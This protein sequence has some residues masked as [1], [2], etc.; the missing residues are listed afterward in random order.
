MPQYLRMTIPDLEKL[1]GLD[2]SDASPVLYLFRNGE[3]VRKRIS[4]QHPG[5]TPEE[6]EE[7]IRKFAEEMEDGSRILFGG[8]HQG[9]LTGVAGLEIGR[10]YGEN[11]DMFK[12]G[13]GTLTIAPRMS[14]IAKHDINCICGY[15]EEIDD[16]PPE[17]KDKINERTTTLFD[18][19]SY[20]EWIK[21]KR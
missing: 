8:F 6:W 13:D 17:I 20:Q 10:G 1:A 21:T 18:D 4:V 12:L 15:T 2:R 5:F 7:R 19:I 16:L 3:L 14:T 9:L 11:K